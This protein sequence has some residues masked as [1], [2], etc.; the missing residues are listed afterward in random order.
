MPTDE[1]LITTLDRY[2]E[3]ALGTRTGRE[4][5]V[6]RNEI[7]AIVEPVIRADERRMLDAEIQELKEAVTSMVHQFGYSTTIDGHAYLFTGGLS[8]L[9]SAFDILEWTDPHPCPESECEADRCGEW[10]TCGT[11]T[12]DGYKRLCDTHFA[13]TRGGSG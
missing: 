8:A 7:M 3:N 4:T 6:A 10:A 1:Q 5:E 11:P 2:L 13:L 9:E 12:P